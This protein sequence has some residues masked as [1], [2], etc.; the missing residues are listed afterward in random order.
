[1]VRFHAR[2]K[3]NIM[4]STK[5]TSQISALLIRPHINNMHQRILKALE[6]LNEG[7]FRQIAIEADLEP[8]QV[9]K[10]MSEL[11]KKGYVDGSLITICQKTNRPVTLWKIKQS[12]F[13][14]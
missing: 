12:L 11:E 2:N 13:N 8:D 1:M 14:N 10:R 6:N 5:I 3:L 4:K 7:T 9:W